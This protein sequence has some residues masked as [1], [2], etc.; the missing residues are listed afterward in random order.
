M[1][2][3]RFLRGRILLQAAWRIGFCVALA[4]AAILA[5]QFIRRMRE[6]PEP[7]LEVF[8]NQPGTALIP[9]SSAKARNR[10]R[11]AVAT[12]VS[13]EETFSIYRRFVQRISK[14]IGREEVFIVR[15]S[16]EGVNL[17]LMRGEVD[18]AFICT[19]TYLSAL[20]RKSVKLLVQPEFEEGKLYQSLLMVPSDSPFRTW[21]DLRDK[22]I[23]F[24]D[25]E[26]FTGCLLPS[27]AI[28]AKG[29][30]PAEYFNKIVYTGSHDRSITAVSTNIVDAAAVM[31]LVWISTL[32]KQPALEKQVKIIWHSDI[33]GPPPI[34]VPAGLDGSLEAAL[35]KALLSMHEDEEGR[36][37][38]AAIG[39]KRFVPAKPESY[40]SA[41]KLY[42]QYQDLQRKP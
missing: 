3:R 21:E 24:T 29:Y 2:L 23:A 35:R 8:Q 16:Y 37:I 17:A 14:D 5:M 18:A 38:L 30:A 22:V 20:D 15:P 28:A 1:G 25:R 26:S 4:G 32:E 34:V 6:K 12:M 36:K 42:K 9:D 31:S 19:G 41:I 11:F 10:L 40:V 13:A 27:W 33:F 39:I 7:F